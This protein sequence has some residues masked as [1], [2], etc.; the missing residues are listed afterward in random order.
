MSQNSALAAHLPTPQQA[1]ARKGAE[2][3]AVVRELGVSATNLVESFRL[4]P[5]GG[6]DFKAIALAAFAGL[7]KLTPFDANDTV[8]VRKMTSARKAVDRIRSEDAPLPLDVSR[9]LR[10]IGEALFASFE[11]PPKTQHDEKAAAAKAVASPAV[12]SQPSAKPTVRLP[13]NVLDRSGANAVYAA[14]RKSAG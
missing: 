13:T 10:L 14:R 6:P 5:D 4:L 1:L 7:E 3:F 12:K 2:P 9:A 11:E 8:Y